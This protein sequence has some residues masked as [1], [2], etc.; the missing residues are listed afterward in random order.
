MEVRWW[1][2][3]TR[4]RQE[5]GYDHKQLRTLVQALWI[6]GSALTPLRTLVL[7]LWTLGSALTSLRTLV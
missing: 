1:T 5:N 2:T 7:A 6:L 3:R 4:F